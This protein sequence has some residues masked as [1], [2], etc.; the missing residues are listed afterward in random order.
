MAYI[1]NEVP[2]GA[3]NGVNKTYTTAQTLYQAILITVDGPIYTGGVTFTGNTFTLADAPTTS[4]T[5]SYYT[6]AISGSLSGTLLVSDVKTVFTRFKK[7]LTD[8]S[9]STFIDWCD[10]I[11]KFAYRHLLGVDAERFIEESTITSTVGQEW[12]Y[13]PNDFRDI[14]RFG[15]GLYDYTNSLRSPVTYPIT[16]PNSNITGFYV[17]NDRLYFTP[18][19]QDA[20]VYMLRYVP[21]EPEIDELTDYFIAPLDSRYMK[22]LIGALDVMYNE[23]DESVPEEGIADQRFV[24]L[25][26]ELSRNVKQMPAVYCLDD[27]TN[28][29]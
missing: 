26:D 4:I 7:D 17:K 1:S 2:T 6:T 14:Q 19:P 13:L 23:W 16:N 12:A 9:N 22:Y 8:V 29:F 27:F 10:W 25:L 21:N 5:I 15:C 24:R 28:S 11:N 3:I 20:H 18:T